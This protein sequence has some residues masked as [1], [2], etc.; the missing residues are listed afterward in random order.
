MN[1]APRGSESHYW[2]GLSAA[3]GL[4]S[5][6]R[7]G[8]LRRRQT[9]SGILTATV[10]KARRQLIGSSARCPG[11]ATSDFILL[12][13]DFEICECFMAGNENY[14]KIVQVIGSRSTRRLRPTLPGSTTRS[15]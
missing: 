9:I 15:R 4:W 13:S 6:K 12:T 5:E 3:A 8:Q 7:L 10:R 11:R 14:G 2:L 1:I